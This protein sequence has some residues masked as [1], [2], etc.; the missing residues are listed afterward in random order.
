MPDDHAADLL[1]ALAASLTVRDH[2]AALA[3]RDVLGSH[4]PSPELG[5]SGR[6]VRHHRAFGRYARRRVRH[7]RWI[8]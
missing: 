2:I 7:V 8:T 6:S 3:V 1:A 4:G 5:R